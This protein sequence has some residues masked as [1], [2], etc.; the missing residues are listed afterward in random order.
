ML[1]TQMWNNGTISESLGGLGWDL[2]QSCALL[3]I[4][5]DLSVTFDTINNDNLLNHIWE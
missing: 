2:D 5:L 4:L 1:Q 3:F